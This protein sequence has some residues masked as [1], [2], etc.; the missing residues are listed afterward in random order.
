MHD[1]VAVVLGYKF[2]HDIILKK[3]FDH[4]IKTNPG[5]TERDCRIHWKRM[6]CVQEKSKAVTEALFKDDLP[7]HIEVFWSPAFHKNDFYVGVLT[8]FVE[9][10]TC[11]TTPLMEF[12][13]IVSHGRTLKKSVLPL[14]NNMINSAS[15]KPEFHHI[16]D[17]CPCCEDDD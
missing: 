11:R 15:E 9:A 5:F 3:Y 17:Y 6:K 16:P 13:S 7:N 2:K 12:D 1:V 8:S 10:R 4:L 14:F